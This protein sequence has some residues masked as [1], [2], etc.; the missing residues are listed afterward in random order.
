MKKEMK[1]IYFI[2]HFLLFF[3]NSLKV[4]NF[5]CVLLFKVFVL[6]CTFHEFEIFFYQTPK[7]F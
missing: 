4:F 3:C 7:F 5:F 1:I 6:F 2:V